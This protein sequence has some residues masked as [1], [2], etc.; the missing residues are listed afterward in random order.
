[1]VGC[2]DDPRQARCVAGPQ[3][4]LAYRLVENGAELGA[5]PPRVVEGDLME[6]R[7]GEVHLEE[8]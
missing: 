1:M 8:G 6:L 2:F 7:I 5:K 3:L 4:S